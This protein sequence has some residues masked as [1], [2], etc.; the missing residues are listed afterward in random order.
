MSIK[1]YLILFF[2]NSTHYH[3]NELRPLSSKN[4][5]TSLKT[6]CE[7][8]NI[9]S[10]FT[11]PVHIELLMKCSSGLSLLCSHS[12][13]NESK[14]SQIQTIFVKIPTLGYNCFVQ[15]YYTY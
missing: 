3:K 13:A 2:H 4:L 15:M 9:P 5:M 12:I 10:Y 1:F 8:Q 14:L 11:L 6:E 7:L